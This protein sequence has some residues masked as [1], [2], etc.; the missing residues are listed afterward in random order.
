MKGSATYV[1]PG[2]TVEIGIADE[3]GGLMSSGYSTLFT[4]PL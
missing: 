3:S 2:P 4:M 1:A